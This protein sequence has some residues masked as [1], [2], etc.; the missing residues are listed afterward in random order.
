ME[1]GLELVLLAIEEKSDATQTDEAAFF[2]SIGRLWAEA[3]MG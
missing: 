1:V 3:T 2:D